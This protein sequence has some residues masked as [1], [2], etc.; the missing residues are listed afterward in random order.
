MIPFFF[1][2]DDSLDALV[3]STSLFIGFV[4]FVSSLGRNSLVC[5][6]WDEILPSIP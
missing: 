6:Y 3:V 1:P 5:G 2:E 4:Q